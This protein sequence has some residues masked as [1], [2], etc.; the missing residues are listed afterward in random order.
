MIAMAILLILIATFYLLVVS[1]LAVRWLA[2]LKRDY[3]LSRLE[4]Q[5]GLLIIAIAATL[6]VFVIPFAYSELLAKLEREPMN[7]L[8]SS[9]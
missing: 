9:H 3:Q 5:S 4:K 1:L 7:H 2:F 8:P 6:W